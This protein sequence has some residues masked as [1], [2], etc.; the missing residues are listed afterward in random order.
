RYFFDSGPGHGGDGP[1]RA[2]QGQGGRGSGN[3]RLPGDAQDGGNWRGNVQEATGRRHGGGQRRPVAARH[4]ERRRGARDG[5]GKA[6]VD[7]AAHEVQGGG[8]HPDE[9]RRRAAH[10]VLQGI[11]SAV[12]FAHDGRDRGG[13]VAGGDGD[14]DA[15]RQR[16]PGDRTDHAGGDGKGIAVRDSRRRAHGGRGH[17]RGDYYLAFSRQPSG[18]A[19]DCPR[20]AGF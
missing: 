3:R 18:I 8:V 12:L 2:R 16:E 19:F 20:M 13:G 17:D 11:S 15:G 4:R 5:A 10:A 9:G 1:D 7:H 14:G 6:G